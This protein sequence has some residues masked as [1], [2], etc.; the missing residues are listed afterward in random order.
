[1]KRGDIV[2]VAV[3]GDYGKPRPA[4]V[5]QTHLLPP[6]DSTLLCLLTS[7][8]DELALG[9]RLAVAPT[10]ENGLKLPSQIMVEKIVAV[11]RDRCGQIIGR[12]ERAILQQLNEALALITGLTD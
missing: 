11:R 10:P 4:I 9:R 12:L 7:D 2:L 5:I 1:M 3:R 6:T 8:D